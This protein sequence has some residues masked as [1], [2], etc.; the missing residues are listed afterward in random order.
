MLDT[1]SPGFLSRG[2][3]VKEEFNSDVIASVLTTKSRQSLQGLYMNI[4]R[5]FYT[6]KKVSRI[7][8]LVI[9]T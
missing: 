7:D 4:S 2:L 1:G 8:D 3:P 9:C 6:F 5:I